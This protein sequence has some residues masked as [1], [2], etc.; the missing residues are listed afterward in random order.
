MSRPTRRADPPP[1]GGRAGGRA[2]FSLIEILI[3]L[4]LM[5]L[6]TAIIMPG[7]SRMLDQATAHA[8]FFEFQ[9]DVSNLRREAN[10]SGTP[11]R[12]VDPATAI[13]PDAG[14]RRIVL[15]DPWRYTIAPAMEIAEGGVCAPT[16]VNLL[17]SDRIVMTLRSD[18]PD[19]RFSRLQTTAA[20]PPARSSR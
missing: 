16:T 17:N 11:L 15:R 6:A 14:D 9:R 19:C 1:A 4:T 12:L 13:D 2:G 7:M 8:V 3:V 10:R 20:R 5:A 18:T